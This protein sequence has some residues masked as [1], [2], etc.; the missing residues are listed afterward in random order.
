MSFEEFLNHSPTSE[1]SSGQFLK[2]WK[3]CNPPKVIVWLH[4][5]SSF[6][7]RWTHNWPRI[8]TVEDSDTHTKTLEVKPGMWVCHESEDVLKNQFYRDK[9]DR[10]RK[11]PPKRCPICK[12]IEWVWQEIHAGN[13]SWVKPIFSFEGTDGKSHVLSAGGICNMFSNPNL[14]PNELAEMKKAGIYRTEAYKQN[15]M[16]KCGYIFVVVDNDDPK[17]GVQI[18]MESKSLGEQMKKAIRDTIDQIA[19]AKRIDREQAA[20]LGNPLRN[21]YPFIWEYKDKAS[22][23]EMYRVVALKDMT[24][25]D[26]VSDLIMNEQ[27]PDLSTFMTPGNVTHLRADMEKAALIDMPFSMFFGTENRANNTY[28]KIMQDL[29]TPVVVKAPKEEYN[30]DNFPVSYGA[31]IETD[32]EFYACDHCEFDGLKK[33]DLNCPKCGS[34]YT[35]DGKL[36]TRPCPSCKV[37]VNVDGLN[38][39]ITTCSGCNSYVNVEE[40]KVVQEPVINKSNRP[41]WGRK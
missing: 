39:N 9:N 27:A 12:M 32:N 7:A 29:N 23:G 3:K 24:P 14:N 21:P 31:A 2:K 6:Q 10:I 13:L 16:S 11:N 15:A 28:R 4:T 35:P 33:T 18:T 25:D 36:A 34:T 20:N 17:S 41:A 38:S 30:D 5:L 40:W 8:A 26:V 19:I 22:F 1:R 37:Q